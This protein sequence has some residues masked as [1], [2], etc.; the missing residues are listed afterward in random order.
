MERLSRGGDDNDR[1]TDG[2]G[3]D[4]L[5]GGEGDDILAGGLPLVGL[6]ARRHPA[7]HSGDEGVEVG[8]LVQEGHHSG[9]V[10]LGVLV[11]EHVAQARSLGHPL[12]EVVPEDAIS[13]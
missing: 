2:T 5:D 11:D 1:I 7:R 10:H 4:R 12:G 8:E 3:N 6:I 13:G 9:V